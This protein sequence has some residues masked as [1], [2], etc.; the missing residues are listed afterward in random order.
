[1][2]NKKKIATP[3]RSMCPFS[4]G[5]TEKQDGMAIKSKGGGA[6]TPALKSGYAAAPRRG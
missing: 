6:W 4:A 5:V 3:L 2:E 1:M